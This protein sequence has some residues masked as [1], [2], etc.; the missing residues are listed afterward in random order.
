MLLSEMISVALQSIKA[1][2]FRGFL[3]MLGIIIGVG[4][5]IAMVALSTGAQR[6]MD[7]QIDSLGASIL[8]VRSGGGF[9]HGVSKWNL[10]LSLP[11]ADALEKDLSSAIAVNPEAERRFQVKL[12]NKNQN[13]RIVGTRP[14]FASVH[15]YKIIKP[16]SLYP[17]LF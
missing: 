11:D 5:V 12:G 10:T 13:L 9:S 7:E 6:A 17:Y 16:K 4:S 2:I 15:N 8:T 3:T 1:N 14:N